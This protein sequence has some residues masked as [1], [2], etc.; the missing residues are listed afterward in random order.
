VQWGNLGRGGGDFKGI[1][2]FASVWEKD[3]SPEGN[4][5]AGNTLVKM[6]NCLKNIIRIF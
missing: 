1:L 6:V 2:Y 5:L 3:D 4:L